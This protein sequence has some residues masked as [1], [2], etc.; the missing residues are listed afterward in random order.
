MPGDPPVVPLAPADGADVPANAAGIGVG[1]QCPA[2]RIAVF[3]P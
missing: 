2:Y 1:F 3:G